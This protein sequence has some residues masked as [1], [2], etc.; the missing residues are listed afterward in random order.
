LQ[1]LQSTLPRLEA[2]LHL[3][4]HIDPALAADQ[5]VGAVTA[6]QRFQ[7]VTDLHV[8]NPGCLSKAV[9]PF[10]LQKMGFPVGRLAAR[11][12]AVST[13]KAPNVNANRAFRMDFGF[14]RAA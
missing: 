12:G 13:I 11:D 7:R 10:S 1:K 14:H 5:T 3:V 9:G 6:T 4:D 2:A 8:K